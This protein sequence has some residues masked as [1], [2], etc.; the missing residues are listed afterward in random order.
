M[1]ERGRPDDE[2]KKPETMLGTIAWIGVV[3][4]CAI[5]ALVILAWLGPVGEG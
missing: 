3:T 1:S 5:V 4:V 2:P